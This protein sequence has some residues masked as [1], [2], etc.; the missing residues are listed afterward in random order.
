MT[1]S[2]SSL[3]KSNHQTTNMKYTTLF[4]LG[5]CLWL[6]GCV[7][8]E[9]SEDKNRENPPNILLIFTDQQHA[10]MMSA[11]GNPYVHTPAMDLLA[12]SGVMFTEAYCTSP[13]CGPARS[14]IVTGL[15][16]H[17]TG[18]EWNGQSI[19]EGIPNVGELLRSAGYRTVWGG[20]WHLPE[21][22]PQR[23]AD[24]VQGF[25]LL[26]LT[27]E[28]LTPLGAYTDPPLTTATVDFLNNY[29]QQ[30]PLFLAVSYHNPHD[31]CFYARKNG[32]FTETDSLLEIRFWNA[33][34]RLPNI[35]G[36]NP[37]FLDSLPPLP[38]NYAR[39]V[40]EPQFITDKREKHT[41]Y[42]VETYLTSQEFGETEWRGYLN[43]YHRLT[44]MVDVEIG[45]VLQALKDN[46]MW[47]N[48]LIVFTSDH[49]DGA[50]AHQW[51]AKL[52]LY[53]E[54]ANIPMIVAWPGK[55]KTAV[56]DQHLVS[57][58]DIVPTMLD[59]AGVETS[60]TFTGSSLK[61]LIEGREVDWREYVVM[62]LADFK[63]DPSRKGRMVRSQFYKYN[64]YSSGEE[65]LF[66]L[67]EDPGETK[68]LIGEA[69][70]GGIAERHRSFLQA[71]ASTTHDTLMEWEWEE[72]P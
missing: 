70:L 72:K 57:Q 35:I 32:W 11:A 5:C 43:A 58:I 2:K 14:S 15:M 18:V 26:P 71:W 10:E 63:P 61:P 54:S 59:Y 31:I 37:A 29:D 9:Q 41:E 25:E 20:K 49:G 65:Q 69:V 45:K 12:E 42:G 60:A 30:Q 24:T 17:E 34:R 39:N 8:V 33:K 47:E 3:R 40:D 56:D 52:S 16:P 55:T 44:E 6:T 27:D 1:A 66:H 64:R 22:Y 36:I 67:R 28:E 21:S 68:N 7:Q 13:V 62:E 4:I 50:A 53:E 51:A 38:H 46:G 19:R 48:T 23:N